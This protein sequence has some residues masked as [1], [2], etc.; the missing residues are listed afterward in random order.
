MIRTTLTRSSISRSVI[1]ARQLHSSP[2][3]GKTVAEKVT[4]VADKVNKSVGKG[5]ASAI[6]TGEKVVHSTKHTFGSA[7]RKATDAT[8]DAQGMAQEKVNQASESTKQATENVRQKFNQAAGEA[9]NKAD[10]V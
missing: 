10:R 9:G 2:V 7:K 3:V 8:Q 4:E 1:A 6:D 5:L